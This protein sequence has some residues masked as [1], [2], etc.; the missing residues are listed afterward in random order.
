MDRTG[1]DKA[2]RP[3]SK[4]PPGSGAAL[5]ISPFVVREMNDARSW[6]SGGAAPTPVLLHQL[7]RGQG[8]EIAASR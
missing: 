6:D 4:G 5:I 2:L 8:A 3:G 1:A 7:G